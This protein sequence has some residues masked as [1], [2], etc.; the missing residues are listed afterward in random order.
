MKLE[1][2][3]R[4]VV[5]NMRFTS[6]DYLYFKQ[7]FWDHYPESQKRLTTTLRQLA[8]TMPHH[9]YQVC[10]TLRSDG[11]GGDATEDSAGQRYIDE[12]YV[13]ST[14]DQPDMLVLAWVVCA[15]ER[16]RAEVGLEFR[17]VMEALKTLS[18]FGEYNK[19]KFYDRTQQQPAEII[20]IKAGVTLGYLKEHATM[21]IQHSYKAG[22]PSGITVWIKPNEDE[23]MMACLALAVPAF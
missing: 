15:Q 21:A 18:Y 7:C 3:Y 17:P 22:V 4:V 12:H 23:Q 9:Q 10:M 19:G 2:E 14:A 1:N 6:G 16:A 13:M 11:P 20:V 5:P 8:I